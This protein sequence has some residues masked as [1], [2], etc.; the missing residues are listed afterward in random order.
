V[1][2][3]ALPEKYGGTLA[4]DINQNASRQHDDSMMAFSITTCGKGV[5]NKMDEIEA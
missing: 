5:G 1:A 2:P 3:F 4:D